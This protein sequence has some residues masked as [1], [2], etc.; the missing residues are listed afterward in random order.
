MIVAWMYNKSKMEEWVL[1]KLLKHCFTFLNI[2][3]DPTQVFNMFFGGGGSGGGFQSS[4]F[5]GGSP[6]GGDSG[7]E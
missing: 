6:F 7:F 1:V 2:G 4:F 3:I 5:S